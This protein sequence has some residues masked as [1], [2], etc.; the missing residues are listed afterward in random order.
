VPNLPSKAWPGFGSNARSAEW[1]RGHS[2]SSSDADSGSRHASSRTGTN[3]TQGAGARSMT[4]EQAETIDLV[5]LDEWRERY[6][7]LVSVAPEPY[8]EVDRHGSVVEW[9]PQAEFRFGWD[10]QEVLG[11]HF[12][13]FVSPTSLGRSTFKQPHHDDRDPTT[14]AILGGDH[15]RFQILHRLGGTVEVEGLSFITG[16]GVDLR[17]VSFLR[18]VADPAEAAIAHAELQDTLTGLPNRSLFGY[19]L[20]HS[21]SRAGSV[22]GSIAVVLMDLDRFKSINNSLG[23]DAGDE[24]LLAIATRLADVSGDAE[25]IARFGGDEFLALFHDESGGAHAAASD[26]IE[27][28][29]ASFAQ[30]FELSG[31]EVFVDVSFGIALNTFGVDDPKVLLSNAEAA[32]YQAK[33]WGGSSVETFGESMRLEV[34]D[35]MSTEHSLH[36]ALERSELMLHYQPVVEVASV[37]VVGVEALIRWQ[38]PEQGLLAPCRFIPVAEESGLIISIGAWVLEEACNQLSDWNH[39]SIGDLTASSMEVN[40]SARQID[41]PHIVE[42]V[43]AILART[44]LPPEHLTL[45]ITESA[46]MKDAASALKV[47]KTLKELGVLLAIDDFGTGYSSL[48]YLQ[49]FP[50]D[51]LKV[52]RSFVEQLGVSVESEEIVSAVIRLAHALGLEVVAEGV[53]T[54][55]QLAALQSFDCDLAQGFL[56]SRPL[57]A[58]EIFSTLGLA[59]PA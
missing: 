7:Q 32:M 8:V 40:L 35:R 22:P 5:R 57:P 48:S 16:S 44:G 12:M 46:L 3:G 49:R 41:D 27:R 43:E 28:V 21:L 38:H 26:F 36:R 56:F 20:A 17:T 1:M 33:Y 31:T 58:L 37:R 4:T 47:L 6:A 53:E 42:T 24:L 30:S 15:T 19:Q 13:E 59:V 55:E 52:D 34:F 51:I 45:E 25:V 9:N 11:H 2:R 29:R 39:R 54:T 23:H 10:R 14:A 50:L 18:P